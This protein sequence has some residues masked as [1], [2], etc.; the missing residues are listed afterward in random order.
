MMTYLAYVATA[1]TLGMLMSALTFLG[2]VE[3]QHWQDR[4]RYYEQRHD[5]YT[6]MLD[7]Y[8]DDCTTRV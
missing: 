6:Q 8:G 4:Q 7:R 3:Y 1:A 5:F 2:V